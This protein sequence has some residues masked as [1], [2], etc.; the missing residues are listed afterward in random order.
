MVQETGGAAYEVNRLT[1]EYN[2][3]VARHSEELKEAKLLIDVSRWIVQ[4]K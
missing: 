4:Q 2:A 3:A 1:A